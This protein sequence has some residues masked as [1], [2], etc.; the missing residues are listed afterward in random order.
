MKKILFTAFAAAALVSCSDDD[1]TSTGA[2]A[3]AGKWKLTAINSSQA[4]DGNGDGVATTNLMVEAGACFAD[5]YL[6]F[7]GLTM[8]TNF[9]S[10]PL[11]QNSCYTASADG[12]YAVTG[13]NVT[14]SIN[15]EGESDVTTYT[16][17]DNK[18]TAT[19]PDFYEVEVTVNGVTTYQSID[20]TLVYTEQ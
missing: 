13:N 15:F 2:E 6:Q 4:V 16:R 17:N 19:I 7:T 3:I 5:S 18:L 11:S 20:A 12:A 14:V 9:L 8:V 1:S 10:L